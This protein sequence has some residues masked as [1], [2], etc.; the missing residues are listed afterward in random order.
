[1]DVKKLIYAD[2]VRREIIAADP[3]LAYIVDRIKPVDVVEV[4]HGKRLYNAHELAEI[5]AELFEDSCACNFNGIDDWLMRYDGNIKVFNITHW[6]L[7]PRPP[8]GE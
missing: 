1:M 8:K 2:D 7:L 4:V 6:T 3:K 5:I